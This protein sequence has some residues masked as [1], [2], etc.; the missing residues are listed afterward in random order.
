MSEKSSMG[1]I[2]RASLI[3]GSA[4]IVASVIN[5][6][7]NRAIATLQGTEGIGLLGQFTSFQTL[8]V[9]VAT[10]G[11]A[12]GIIKY[13]SQY[14]EARQFDRVRGS[15]RSAMLMVAVASLSSMGLLMV[16]SSWISNVLVGDSS[17]QLYVILIAASVPMASLA[18]TYNSL[19][20]GARAIKTLAT[21]SIASSAGALAVTVPAVYYLKDDGIILQLAVASAIALALNFGYARRVEKR[22]PAAASPPRFEREESK[23]L[24]HY[25]AVSIAIGLAL[26]LTLLVAQTVVIR[27]IGLAENGLFTAAWALYWLYVGFATTSISVYLFPTT[28][29]T[30]DQGELS[31]QLNNGMRFLMIATTPIAAI[32]VLIPGAILTLLY[33]SEFTNA[34]TLLQLLAVAG[35]F[36][37][38]SYPAAMTL[39]A[40]KRLK[41]YLAVELSWYPVFA[42]ITLT[43]LD[44]V[45]IEAI[46]IAAITACVLMATLHLIFLRRLLGLI[47]DRKNWLILGSGTALTALLLF[48]VHEYDLLGFVLGAV[49]VPAW[50]YLAT[51][52]AERRW[53]F[54][55]LLRRPS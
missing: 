18:L 7:R 9:G 25:G 22:W 36:R 8:V 41:V 33:S 39:M 1:M 46:G 37:I 27:R 35:A 3:T 43:L 21:I 4:A 12:V 47:Y 49:L 51:D 55:K 17:A 10:L 52:Q 40:K 6:V 54:S 38:I 48:T 15:F 24:L 20:N 44:P 32:I 50:L 5:L 45:G 11:L 26:P 2:V 28:S 30:R 42:A 14:L 53:F 19:V 34:S 13:L 16:L 31:A 29:A 23:L